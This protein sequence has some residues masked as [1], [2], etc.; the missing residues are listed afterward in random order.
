MQCESHDAEIEN[1]EGAAL[2]AMTEVMGLRAVE[3]RAISNRVGDSFDKWAVDEAVEAL[4]RELKR[5]E[6]EK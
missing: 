6:D 1:M 4:A 5:L 2:F 3:V